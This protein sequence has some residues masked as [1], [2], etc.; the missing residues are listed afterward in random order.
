VEG[1]ARIEPGLRAYDA[2]ELAQARAAFEAALLFEPESLEARNHLAV[3]SFRSSD[4][5]AAAEEW[6]A[7]LELARATGIELPEPVHLNLARAL[8]QAGRAGEVREVLERYLAERP[9]GEHAQATR[10]MLQRLEDEARAK[11]PQG[12]GR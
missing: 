6:R 3:V 4:F 12:S 1:H 10:E 9:G 11:P 2:G 8:Y 5:E 7:V